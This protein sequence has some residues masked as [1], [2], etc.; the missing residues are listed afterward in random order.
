MQG[1]FHLDAPAWFSQS[2]QPPHLRTIAGAVLSEVQIEIRYQGWTA[3]KRRRVAPLGLVLKGGGWYLAGSVE[4]SVRTY[5]VARVLDC[6]VLEEGFVRP[7]HFDLAAYW[8]AATH[9]LEAELHPNRATVRLSP[10]GLKVLDA[11]SQPYV[12]AGTRLSEDA[13][14]AGW[15]IAVVPVGKSLLHAAAE[16]LRL[17][18]EAEVLDPPTLRQRMAE[19]TQAMAACYQAPTTRSLEEKKK[20]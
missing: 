7:A 8:Q 2:E 20:A 19:L 16:L 14:A 17:G 15:R 18:P 12:K 13:D 6:V 9:R 4:G 5:R 1:R 10:L 11:L 3:E